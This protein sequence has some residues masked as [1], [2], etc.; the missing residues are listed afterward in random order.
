MPR[1]PKPW[2]AGKESEMFPSLHGLPAHEPKP[3]A[4]TVA[5]QPS[6]GL[7]MSPRADSAPLG[8]VW[9]FCPVCRVAI[10]RGACGTHPDVELVAFLTQL[11]APIA[12]EG[13]PAAPA[14][15]R[16]TEG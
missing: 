3:M 7:E 6:T 13:E 10:A 9:R 11:P 15:K 8:K 16:T 5:P 4:G 1:K 14:S 2:S 12:D